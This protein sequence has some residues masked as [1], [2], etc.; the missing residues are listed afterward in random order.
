[1]EG[2]G[3]YRLVPLLTPFCGWTT[4]VKDTIF[5]V[6][7]TDLESKLSAVVVH[8]TAVHEAQHVLHGLT[9]QDLIRKIVN[10]I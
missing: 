5:C 7:R 8:P 2:K 10:E 6:C 3:A 9:V 4:P 1:M